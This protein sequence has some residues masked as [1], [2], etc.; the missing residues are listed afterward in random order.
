LLDSKVES[1]P[2]PEK[3]SQ[4]IRWNWKG[5]PVYYRRGTEQSC[6]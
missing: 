2:Q 4:K 6:W 1:V 3:H 5:R